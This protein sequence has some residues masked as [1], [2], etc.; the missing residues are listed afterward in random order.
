MSEY[1]E[2]AKSLNN[3]IQSNKLPDDPYNELSVPIKELAGIPVFCS[4]GIRKSSDLL[5]LHVKSIMWVYEDEDIMRD[6]NSLLLYHNSVKINDKIITTEN[7][8]ELF[9]SL[10]KLKF[11]KFIGKFQ[12]VDDSEAEMV[13]P[14][15]FLKNIKN[16]KPAFDECCV[17]SEDTRCFT[18]CNHCLCYECMFKLNETLED[19]DDD[20]SPSAI[21]CPICRNIIAH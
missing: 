1:S 17:C 8:H 19:E 21:K 20:Q 15:S 9:S 11:D 3:L 10:E 13:N 4:I 6:S 16:V 12:T 14:F 5:H 2:V 18:R 7:L